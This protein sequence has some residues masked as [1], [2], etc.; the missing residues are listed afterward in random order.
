MLTRKRL[1]VFASLASAA[2]RQ[3]K[4]AHGKTPAPKIGVKTP[5]VQIP[6]ANLKAEAEFEA[7]AQPEWIFFAGA[8]FAPGKDA[9]EKIDPKTNKKAEPIAGLS[10]PCGAPS[11]AFR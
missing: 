4:S 6:F 1:T 7:S 2:D 9:I 8:A 10:N 3:P 11:S 5:G